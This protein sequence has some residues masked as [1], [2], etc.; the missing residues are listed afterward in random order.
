VVFGTLPNAIA[1]VGI[2]LIAAS[3]VLVLLLD[4]RPK[5]SA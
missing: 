5:A 4:R 2:C 3:G 1:A